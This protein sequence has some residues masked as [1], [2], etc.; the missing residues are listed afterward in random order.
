MEQTQVHQFMMIAG[1]GVQAL[2]A[3]PSREIGV[4]WRFTDDQDWALTLEAN[5]ATLAVGAGY[6]SADE[7]VLRLHDILTVLGQIVGVARCNRL[8]VRYVN[9]VDVTN[10]D[11]ETW[12]RWF[13]PELAGWIT[14]GIL[15]TDTR[16]VSNLVQSQ[17]ATP[18]DGRL[19]GIPGQVQGIVRVGVVSEGTGIPLAGPPLRVSG[20]SFVLD[21]DLF[22]ES[23]Q[24]F[25]VAGLEAQFR[26]LHSEIDAFFRWSLTAEGEHH[27]GL[28]TE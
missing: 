20:R 11:E 15:S 23:Q 2:P 7:F 10:G 3:L 14:A 18:P 13:R 17:L 25:S 21:L 4:S 5:A 19:E 9:L 28:V 24:D 26:A 1:P 22:V 6:R 12:K 8:G 16:V 27:F